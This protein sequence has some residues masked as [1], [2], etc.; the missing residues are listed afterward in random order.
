MI[1]AA[2]YSAA[3]Q[4]PRERDEQAVE[5]PPRQRLVV[6]A[7]IG[8]LTLI[9]AEALLRLLGLGSPLATDDLVMAF[10][11]TTPFQPH[12]D[13]IVQVSLRPYAKTELLYRRRSDGSLVHRASIEISAFGTRG[14]V[15]APIPGVRRVL[16][17]GDSVTFGQG[18]EVEQ[19][20]PAVAAGALGDRYQLINAGVPSWN[21]AQEVRWLELD[22]AALRPDAVLICFFINDFLPSRY[23]SP[24]DPMPPLVQ[25]APAWA[26][27]EQGPRRASYLLN[28]TYRTLE[29]H[30]RARVAL[31][32]HD[33]YVK[34]LEASFSADRAFV[35]FE[36]V[37]ALT[38]GAG[39]DAAVVL[40]PDLIIG[41]P[42]ETRVIN[43]N[44]AAIASRAGLSVVRLDDALT[45]LNTS[46][47]HVLAGDPHPSVAAH[48]RIGERL[49]A[50]L[51]LW[52]QPAP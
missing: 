22:G 48:E 33:S 11:P 9:T 28:L 25:L 3:M 51:A 4:P 5:S 12:R 20:F 44:V 2:S 47:W 35:A 49:A 38:R 30:R 39:V 16:V 43:D 10:E 31:E 6:V 18:V 27:W 24:V 52:T 8:L 41:S 13:G 1:L 19:A 21:L 15:P 46:R 37:A 45:D 14:P 29:R 34:M 50:E 36:R 26:A 7:V 23:D 40:L 42:V 17:L 32:G